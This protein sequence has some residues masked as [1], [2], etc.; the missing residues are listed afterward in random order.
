MTGTLEEFRG[1]ARDFLESVAARRQVSVTG[2]GV[3]PDRV[4]LLEAPDH[5]QEALDLAASR[6]WRQQVY[7]AGFGWLAGP[8]EYGGGGLDS[9][10]DE[11]YRVLETGY[12]V[13]GRAFFGIARNMLAPAILDHGTE[14]L[15]QTFLRPLFRGDLLACQ[16]F[17]EPGAGSDLAGAR[18]RAVPVD[19]GYL[20]N[21]QKVWTSYAHVADVG[22]LL[23][24]TDPEAP[25][26]RGLSMFVVDMD[27]PGITVRPLR[28]MNGGSHFNEVFLDDVFVPADR[29]IGEPG[30][31]WQVA[32]TTLSSERGTVGSGESTVAAP[33]V[34]RLAALATHLGRES[35]PL[36]RQALAQVFVADRVMSAVNEL[37]GRHAGPLGSVD[38][39]LFSRQLERVAETATDLLADAAV[40][41]NGE[42]GTFAWADFLLSAPG[43]RFAGG[44]DEIMLNI[45]GERALGLPRE[46]RVER[47]DR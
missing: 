12:E 24:R 33:Y 19:G 11:A 47:T 15:K 29:L 40:A 41:D 14:Y 16:L 5:E 6:A 30:S 8:V 31:G 27:S 4:A 25:K 42:W 18:T 44:T 26:H 17:S 23:A 22:E 39:L 1:R 20:V 35:D 3:G 21:G 36:T 37:H 13:P 10:H 32:A 38:K 2:W 43:L 45:L 28:Q 7:D 46:P 9:E 34:E